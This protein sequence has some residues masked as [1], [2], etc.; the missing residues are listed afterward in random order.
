MVENLFSLSRA[1]KDENQCGHIIQEIAG[2]GEV[3]CDADQ[4]VCQE[5]GVPVMAGHDE[6]R[7]CAVIK[8]KHCKTVPAPIV[9]EEK[10]N[11]KP[12]DPHLALPNRTRAGIGARAFK[13]VA[14]RL[15]NPNDIHSRRTLCGWRHCAPS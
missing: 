15:P 14:T 3:I 8:T 9:G 1:T 6:S 12:H 11:F 13:R 2:S 10:G 4:S 5:F 7:S